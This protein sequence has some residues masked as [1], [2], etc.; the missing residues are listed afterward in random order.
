M[1]KD[2]MLRLAA[3][4]IAA[5]AVWVAGKALRAGYTAATG[6]EPPRADDLEVPVVRVVMFAMATAAVTAVINVS[7][8]RGVAKA[9]NRRELATLAAV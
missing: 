4:V 5:G 3:P 2:D 6:A 1:E 9:A 7:I 8:Q